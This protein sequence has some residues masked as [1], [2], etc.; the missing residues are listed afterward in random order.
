M[1][2]GEDNSEECNRLARYGRECPDFSHFKVGVSAAK[3]S[4]MNDRLVWVGW[5]WLHGAFSVICC[6]T[7]ALAVEMKPQSAK[8][9]RF[10]FDSS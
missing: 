6:V 2:P 8:F 10:C 5:Y 9:V 3:S 1:I 7:C 4:A